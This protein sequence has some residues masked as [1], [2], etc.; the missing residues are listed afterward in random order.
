[1]FSRIGVAFATALT[2]SAFAG[3][4]AVAATGTTNSS[5]GSPLAAAAT[6]FMNAFSGNVV[7]VA[8]PAQL[9]SAL[10]GAKP[11]QTIHLA[12]GRYVGN[13]N[14][15]KPAT[16]NSPITLTGSR[17]AILDGRTTS[18]GYTLHL[19]GASYWHLD[20]FSIVH[21]LK[22]LVLDSTNHATING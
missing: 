12:D 18:T 20:G 22:G 19:N 2:I 21:G 13:F 10:A 9:R 3:G 1:V 7:N 17:N 4:S 11:G 16:A 6:L 8:N 14:A 15:N 5:P